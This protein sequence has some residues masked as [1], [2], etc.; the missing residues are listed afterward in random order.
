MAEAVALPAVF[1]VLRLPYSTS[2][3]LRA[4]PHC[5]YLTFCTYHLCDREAERSRRGAGGRPSASLAQR[6]TFFHRK[7]PLLF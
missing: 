6:P 4:V 2:A 5:V 1:V 3:M 7:T